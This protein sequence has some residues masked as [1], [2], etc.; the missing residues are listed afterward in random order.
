MRRGSNASGQFAARTRVASSDLDRLGMSM[1]RSAGHA[2]RWASALV[3]V[4]SVT[5]GLKAAVSAGVRFNAAMESNRVA[6]KQFTGS[7]ASAD[8]LLAQLYQ[9]ARK[10]PF[11]FQDITA[12]ARQFMAFGFTSK[13]TA[14]ALKGVGDAV[15]GLG[16]GQDKIDRITLAF[17]QIQSK[18]K[19]MGQ[20]LLQLTEAGIPAYKI[21]AEQLHLTGDQVKRIGELGIPANVA[22]GALLTGMSQRFKGA[23]QEQSKTL[24]GVWSTLK[25]DAS[26]AFGAITSSAMPGLKSLV[27]AVDSAAADVTRIWQR[28][29]LAPEEKFR[30]SWQAI[31][32][33]IGPMVA[34]VGQKIK[35]A[36]LGEK[37]SNAF[38]AAAPKIINALANV[39][40]KAAGAFARAFLDAGP[41]GKI[42]VASV[43]LKKL[44]AFSAAG[45]A[46]TDLFVGG[47]KKLGTLLKR[48]FAVA[49]AEAGVAAGAAAAGSEGLTNAGVFNRIRTSGGR[50]GKVFGKALGL[51]AL[52]AALPFIVDAFRD[53]IEKA[54]EGKGNIGTPGGLVPDWLARLI[55]GR[56]APERDRGG[57]AIPFSRGLP[58]GA[59]GRYVT[60]AQAAARQY[61]IDPAIFVRQIQQESGFNPAAVSSAGALGIAQIMPA[62]AR[63]WHVNPRDPIASLRAAARAMASYVRRYGSYRNALVAYNAGPGAVGR[64][65]LPAE[66]QNYI[67]SILGGGG[68]GDGGSI[69]DAF[70]GGGFNVSA[71]GKVTEGVN[72]FTGEVERHSV[73]GWKRIRM[74]YQQQSIGRR[75]QAARRRKA[76]RAFQRP[77]EAFE[78]E[79]AVIDA[80]IAEAQ[81]T[82]G[83]ADDTRVLGK[84]KAALDRRISALRTQLKSKLSGKHRKQIAEALKDLLGKSSEVAD[85]LYQIATASFDF[86]M[87]GI[88]LAIAKA[89]ATVGKTDDIAAYRRQRDA[90]TSQIAKLRKLLRGS[91]SPERRAELRR[92]LAG[93]IT[94][95]AEL[96]KTLTDLAASAQAGDFDIGPT[97]YGTKAMGMLGGQFGRLGTSLLQAK[98]NT[99]KDTSD[100]LAILQ[101]QL[102]IATS[103]YEQAQATGR[104]D[105]IEQWGNIVLGLRD[106]IKTLSEATEDNTQ[107][108]Q[109]QLDALKEQNE[110][111]RRAAATAAASASSFAGSL[112]DIIS[113]QI[114]GFGVN[115]R[116][117]TAG[118]GA[119]TRY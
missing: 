95:G 119:L 60:A 35:E 30:A 77:F 74:R 23:A 22:I 15:A 80:D 43:I 117:A 7:A 5:Y 21:L 10:T 4:G 55:T 19:V 105:L 47:M 83:T 65:T 87:S 63:G 8:K 82:V 59:R 109:A 37:L 98:V 61:G 32:T 72:P 84:A 76:E 100:D 41:W 94:Q 42:F 68:G 110:N 118:S 1:Q 75:R 103:L 93:L 106:D 58:A 104:A 17:G 97:T 85:T 111:L 115:P 88:D 46:A 12:A 40:V 50:L 99:P 66:T 20:E 54:K 51:A 86:R 70:G 48:Q 79:Y 89:Q 114:V 108:L 39:A 26:Q 34:V 81:Q 11:Q 71:A 102:G 91:L 73:Q 24:V 96:D 56:R 90:I 101:Q 62:T 67:S 25:D 31:Q 113:G 16:G 28:K 107:A 49:G 2:M 112:A 33:D 18:G 69:A 6:L 38:E 53:S 116:A 78:I 64:G 29:D 13:Q 9:T 44:G 52:A 57:G 3:G 45:S 27:T 36:H 14:V 92:L